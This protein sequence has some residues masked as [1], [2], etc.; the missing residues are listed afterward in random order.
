MKEG[1]GGREASWKVGALV[2]REL[3]QYRMQEARV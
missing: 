2:N 1:G 3:H